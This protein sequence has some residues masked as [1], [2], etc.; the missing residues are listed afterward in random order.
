MSKL[1]LA[2]GA[3]GSAHG[4]LLM[5][6]N[7]MDVQLTES[8]VQFR[9]VGGIF[10]LYIMVGETLKSR[11]QNTQAVS[12]LQLQQRP[13]TLTSCQTQMQSSSRLACGSHFSLKSQPLTGKC[14]AEGSQGCCAGVVL[15][16]EAV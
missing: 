12:C 7:G 1:S 13:S 16:I 4:V 14:S 15:S 6:S 2:A 3:D 10:D 8:R 9:I 11:F 5:N